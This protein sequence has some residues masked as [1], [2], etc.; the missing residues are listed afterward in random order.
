[1]H[2]DNLKDRVNFYCR[3]KSAKNGRGA[4][5]SFKFE[6]LVKKKNEKPE[7]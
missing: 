2:E 6:Y 5:N 7:K 1:M 3:V 4:K